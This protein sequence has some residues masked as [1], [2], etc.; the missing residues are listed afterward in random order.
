MMSEAPR[1]RS[2][3]S[4]SIRLGEYRKSFERVAPPSDDALEAL[5]PDERRK[6]TDAKVRQREADADT[7]RRE[8]R[9]ALVNK[10]QATADRIS[11]HTP[12]EGEKIGPPA[13]TACADDDEDAES[14]EPCDLDED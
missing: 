13:P 4:R 1:D 5:P 7:A 11:G 3:D 10:F 2:A 6:K 8:G 9:T 14:D 12:P